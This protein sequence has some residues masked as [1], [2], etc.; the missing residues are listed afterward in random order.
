MAE[1]QGAPD[2]TWVLHLGGTWMLQRPTPAAVAI[3]ARLETATRAGTGPIRL[4]FDSEGLG[5]W[6]TSL[7]IF[8]RGLETKLAGAE[9]LWDRTGL[10]EGLGR[11]LELAECSAGQGRPAAAT[12]EAGVL[13]AIGAGVLQRLRWNR[14]ALAFLGGLTRAAGRLLAGRARWRPT[15][16]GQFLHECGPGALPIVSLIALLVGLI[17][18]FMGAMQLQTFGVQIYVANLVGIG[19]ARDMGAMMTA[20]ILAG[21]TGASFAAQLGTMQVNEEIDA[22][23]TLGFEPI[24]FLVLPRVL[25]LALMMPLLCCY[26]DLMGILGGGLACISL[27]DITPLQYLQ[28][29]WSAVPL[30]HFAGGLV[31]A[32]VYGVVVAMTGCHRGLAC[33]RSAAAVGEATT[34]A[35]VTAIVWIVIWC[36]MLTVLFNQLGI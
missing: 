34:A 2:N 14:Q 1:L 28:Q 31:K 15:D 33:G 10:P 7:A 24:E 16:L 11:L 3:L 22:L 23:R 27:F 5:A 12:R 13:A 17:L 6:D 29:T 36:A 18:A 20:V 9:V 4:R 26:A 21:R 30:H 32:A 19:M 8:L 35:V 25:A